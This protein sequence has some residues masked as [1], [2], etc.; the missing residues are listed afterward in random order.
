MLSKG[1]EKRTD[2]D[3]SNASKKSQYRANEIVCLENKF[4]KLINFDLEQSIA[5]YKLRLGDEMKVMLDRKIGNSM[6]KFRT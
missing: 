6:S 2:F 4:N 5:E 1:I 3:L